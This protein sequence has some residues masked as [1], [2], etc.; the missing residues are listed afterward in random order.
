M[1][2]EIGRAL[3]TQQ[4]FTLDIASVITGRTF[5]ASITRWGKSWTARKTVEECFGHAG[6]I[7]IDPEG[8]YASLRERYPFL[9]IGKDIPIQIETA[10]FMA[11]KVLETKTSVIIDLS[12]V[13]EEL[14]KEYVNAFLRRFF[15]LETTARQPYLV[16]IE[17]AEDFGPEK[18]V[19]TTTCLGIVVNL[20]K[21]G[22]K[23]GI[24]VLLIAHRPAW[25]SKGL[26]S[27][28]ANKALGR[29]DWPGDLEVLEKYAR[30]P[31]EN[32]EKLPT[33]GKGEF[34]FTGDWVKETV[35][36]KV[37]QV[38]TTHLGY[39]PE[40]IP[41][42]PKEL[43]GVIESLQKSLPEVIE[44]IKPTVVSTAEIEAKI[45][46]ELENKYKSKIEAILKT[47][48]EKADRKYR[49]RIDQLQEQLEK[50]SRAQALQP[51]APIT[52]VLEHP[53]VKSR[54]LQLDEKARDLLTWI[55]REPGHT[56][57]ELAARMVSSKDVIASM[58]NKINHTFQLQ[59][60]IGDGKPIR[61]RSMLKRLFIT[62]VAKREI[63]E[64]GK[65]QERA[66][67]LEDE[68]KTLRPIAQQSTTL[69]SEVDRLRN[70][71]TE[72]LEV[73]EKQKGDIK[74]LLNQ[75]TRLT[76]ENEAYSKIKEGFQTLGII[77]PSVDI[78]K[79][80]DAFRKEVVPEVLAEV[81]KIG[82]GSVL[83]S[84]GVAAPIDEKKLEEMIAR[85]VKEVSAAAPSGGPIS[86]SVEL[87]HKV[88]HFEFTVPEEHVKADTTTVQGQI[89]YTILKDPSFWEKR[90]N[91]NEVT[92]KLTSYGW[93]HDTKKE[94]GPALLELC[95]K[96]IFSRVLSTGNYWWYMLRPDAKER[97][98]T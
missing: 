92:T 89:I 71:Y 60:I 44:K 43:Q 14:G 13:E 84:E 77:A 63:E 59:V 58:V 87:E 41:P 19:G 64:L 78:E 73:S 16:V 66:K 42:S 37:G 80:L 74:E 50:L 56:R 18:G 97:I 76:K 90:H 82:L 34:C 9:I 10:E 24:G 38:K 49:V 8:E 26:I 1:S 31:H 29:I 93:T 45:K 15:F 28:C 69:R 52:D 54:M 46:T 36:V 91:P 85:K 86:T 75:I 32:I 94:V 6:I 47:A 61:Y 4:P 51:T 30:V 25:V 48:D 88:T 22:G 98:H 33:L 11:D 20:T 5:M 12:L 27:Q 2:F 7:I 81:K 35:F 55:E 65:L 96:G 95:Q 3:E 62:D 79:R 72:L 53:I 17:E 67:A 23:R 57:E 21:K 70:Q 39:T 83:V 40:V 68:V